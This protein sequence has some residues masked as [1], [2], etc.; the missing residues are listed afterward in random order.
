MIV[1]QNITIY[2]LSNMCQFEHEGKQIKLLPLRPRLNIPIRH[3][4]WSCCQLFL[5][6]LLL[7][8]FRPHLQ[9]IRHTMFKPLS[10]LL[11]TPSQYR[12]VASASALHKHVHKLHKEISDRSKQSNEK[13]TLRID[14]R[15]YLKL[16][17]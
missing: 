1:R 13:S 10:P 3:P 9:L 12:A 15:K 7:L 8:P 4:L 2:G 11:S 17:L 14:R 6:H 5:L 16:L